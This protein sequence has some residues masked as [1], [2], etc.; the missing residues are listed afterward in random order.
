[1]T[2]SVLAQFEQVSWPVAQPGVAA[3]A[4]NAARVDVA[5]MLRGIW[6]A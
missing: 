6:N 5:G 3:P 2:R 1:M 4:Q